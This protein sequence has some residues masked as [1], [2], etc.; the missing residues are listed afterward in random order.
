MSLAREVYWSPPLHSLALRTREF[1]HKAPPILHLCVPR[2]VPL[3][4]LSERERVKP[5]RL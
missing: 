3:L 5:M 1:I 4:R 2:D